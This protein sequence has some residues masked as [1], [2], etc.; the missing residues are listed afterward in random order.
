[1]KKIR[2]AKQI[3]VIRHTYMEIPQGKSLDSYLY[4]KQAKMSCFSFYLFFF[5]LL[6][7]Q[8][9][10]RWN[11]SCLGRRA[12]PSG[13]GEVMRKGNRRQKTCTHACTCKNYTPRIRGGGVKRE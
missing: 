5:F 13:K 2:A 10:G 7:N 1:M 9:T 11:K 3:G 12:G 4:L 6:Q 8:R